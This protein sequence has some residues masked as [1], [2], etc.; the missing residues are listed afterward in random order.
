MMATARI[1]NIFFMGSSLVCAFLIETRIPEPTVKLT[2]GICSAPTFKSGHFEVRGA[3]D[4]PYRALFCIWL[5]ILQSNGRNDDAQ[6]LR[7]KVAQR[8]GER[9]PS[10]AL[11]LRIARSKSRQSI[12]VPKA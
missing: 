12:Q 11:G 6:H 7:I 4:A 9:Q 5:R 3:T 8:P 2:P 1:E 10:G